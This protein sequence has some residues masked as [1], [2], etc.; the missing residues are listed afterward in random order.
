MEKFREYN[1]LSGL[2]AVNLLIKGSKQ[3]LPDNGRI[4]NFIKV[5][6]ELLCDLLSDE[7]WV[8]VKYNIICGEK[9]RNTD[10]ELKVNKECSMEYLTLVLEKL[11]LNIWSYK[12][13]K[14]PKY[15]Y[16]LKSIEAK[17]VK[18]AHNN[19]SADAPGE[20]ITSSIYEEKIGSCLSAESVLIV[21][22][23][24]STLEDELMKNSQ[25]ALKKFAEAKNKSIKI[26]KSGLKN[27]EKKSII[28]TS[29]SPNKALLKSR[30][31]I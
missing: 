27:D 28:I 4:G 15:Y 26:P 14:N 17:V 6:S 25:Y 11:A 31:K 1:G 19:V 21:T 9:K 13:S 7:L 23:N 18:L 3:L 22:V 10:V 2:R 20:I 8:F 24:V 29:Y 30:S 5:S 12:N 16:I